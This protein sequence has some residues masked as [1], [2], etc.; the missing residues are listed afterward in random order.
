METK[1]LFDGFIDIL[2]KR[3]GIKIYKEED[4]GHITFSFSQSHY[5]Q[6]KN[7]MMP[8]HPGSG[9]IDGTLEGLLN[10]INGYKQRFHKV[11]KTED[12]PDF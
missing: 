8:Y 3:V 11:V 12:N 1:L 6:D 7:D 9:G 5:L 2:D 10:K 4:E